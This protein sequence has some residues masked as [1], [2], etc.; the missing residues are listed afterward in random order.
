MA[1]VSLCVGLLVV[2][3]FMNS[4]GALSRASL[5]WNA[6]PNPNIDEHPSRIWSWSDAQFLAGFKRLRHTGSL[7]DAVLTCPKPQ[8]G[9][10][11]P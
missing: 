11:S 9:S 2:G 3:T 1:V 4:H 10:G 8:G 7:R 5:C 6:K